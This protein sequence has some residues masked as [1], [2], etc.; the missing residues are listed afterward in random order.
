MSA[1]RRVAAP[2]AAGMLARVQERLGAEVALDVLFDAPTVAQ[3][4]GRVVARRVG[5][6]D[7]ARLARALDA[8]PGGG[9]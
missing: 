9:A 5:A 2:S 3:L 8:L 6:V 4:A 1:R 7:P